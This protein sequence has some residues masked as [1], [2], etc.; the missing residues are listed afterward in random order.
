MSDILVIEDEEVIRA[1][2]LR[3]LERHDYRVLEAGS[4][5]EAERRCHAERLDLIIADL[6]LPDGQGIDIIERAG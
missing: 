6:R 4:L 3:L 2:L 5:G 1:A